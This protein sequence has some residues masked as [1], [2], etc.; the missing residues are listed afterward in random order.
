MGPLE[1]WEIVI[2][3]I[4]D[5]ALTRWFGSLRKEVARWKTDNPLPRRYAL[6]IAF[7]KLDC[8]EDEIS[9]VLS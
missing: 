9:P 6:L 4:V 5:G 1:A 7:D 2:L 8:L 3:I